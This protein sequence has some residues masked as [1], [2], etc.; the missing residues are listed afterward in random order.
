VLFF[1]GI[2]AIGEEMDAVASL[3]GY[4]YGI[5]VNS[6]ICATCRMC[7]KACPFNAISYNEKTER[8][9]VDIERCQMCA[10]CYSTC[11]ASAIQYLYYDLASIENSIELSSAPMIVV[12]CRGN[13]PSEE[14]LMR[15]LGVRSEEELHSNY[16]TML[17]P[18]VGRLRAE[19]IIDAV[20]S[21][22]RKV[23]LMPCEEDFCR[24]VR[25]SEALMKKVQ[26][27]RRIFSELGISP[28]IEVRRGV[29][30]VEFKPYRCLGCAECQ[31]FC[32]TG[33]ARVIHP[34]P[35]ADFDMDICKGCGICAAVC[36]AHAVDLKGWEFDKISAK[37]HEISEKKVK[38]LVFCCQWCEFG[39]LDRIAERR[40]EGIEI[41]PMPCSG[42][43]DPLHVIQALYEGI[44][45]VMIIACPEEECKLDE[46]SKTALYFTMERLNETLSQLNLEKRVR[47]CF[48]SPKYIGKFDEE[49]QKFLRDIEEMSAT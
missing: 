18:C 8:M 27:L 11:P 41:I 2:H 45:G 31:A 13:V 17:L 21:R 42:R 25:G 12:A 36:P 34:G 39:A 5:E 43:V 3:W 49:L 28:E 38:L 1:I 9:E 44:K 33:A 47:I 48:T 35:V 24:F 14:N 30:K 37:I 22:G 16:F 15:R 4:E 29:L 46:G 23:V 26:M 40:E 7:E 32:P 10:V 20:V 6:D 19:F